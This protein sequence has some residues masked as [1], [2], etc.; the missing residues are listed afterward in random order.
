MLCLKRNL[1]FELHKVLC[2]LRNLHFEVHKVLRTSG[3]A[4]CHE[5]CTSRFTKCCACSKSAL[6]GSQSAVPATKSALR[7]SQ[8]AVPATKSALR[9]SQSAAPATKSAR[10]GPRSTAPARKAANEPHAPVTKSERL[11]DHDH[12]QSTVTKSALRSKAAPIPCTCHEKSTLDHQNTRFPLRLPRSGRCARHHNKSAV[13]RST[14]RNHPDFASLRS[15][16]A[17]RG[18]REA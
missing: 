7:C 14:R 4:K 12:V 18:L 3:F 8:S 13:A 2:L 6:R 15:Q 11:E 1:D 17:L 5:I 16:N 10:Q 9:C